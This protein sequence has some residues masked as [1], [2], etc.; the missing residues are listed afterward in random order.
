MP[1]RDD[2]PLLR[3]SNFEVVIGDRELGF[4]LVGRLSSVTEVDEPD[5]RP[6]HV[7]A[8][9]VM[10][11]ALTS[12]TELYEWRRRIVDGKDDR[13]DVTIRQLSAPGGEVVNSWR[14]VR[15]WPC[16]WSGPVFDAMSNDIAFEELELTFEDIVWLKH[17]A[18]SKGD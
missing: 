14:L 2:E 17:D 6:S 16:R 5:N 9:V 15:A 3:I 10:K 4:A 12:S 18:R 8:T 11:R 13:R 7:L 1:S